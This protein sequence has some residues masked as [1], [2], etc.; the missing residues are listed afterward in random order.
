[1]RCKRLPRRSGCSGVVISQLVVLFQ[2][3]DRSLEGRT[4]CILALE[5]I[6]GQCVSGFVVCNLPA[7]LEFCVTAATDA[8]RV[9]D[10]A[11]VA[12]D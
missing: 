3:G 8:Y 9:S 1:M 7:K 10:S 4:W 6:E 5:Q 11:V 2:L 12:L